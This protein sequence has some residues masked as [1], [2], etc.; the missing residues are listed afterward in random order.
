MN[1]GRMG[2]ALGVALML[3]L[4]AGCGAKPGAARTAT[5]VTPSAQKPDAARPETPGAAPSPAESS[6]PPV[7]TPQITAGTEAAIL[8]PPRPVVT[9]ETP[10]PREKT[11]ALPAAYTWQ[12]GD[13]LFLVAR[14]FYGD[15]RLWTKIVE[16]NQAIQ[17]M[18]EIPVGT[19]LL[20]PAR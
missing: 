7:P 12:A 1:L 3:V 19:V 8:E 13:R 18:S 15:G 6:R 10:A 14:R 20:I 4:A 11:S 17:T 2:A 5:P 16:A 9:V